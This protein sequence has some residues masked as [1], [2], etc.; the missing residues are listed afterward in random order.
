MELCYLEDPVDEYNELY[1]ELNVPIGDQRYPT[2]SVE[3][4]AQADDE[5]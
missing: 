1:R 3:A 2:T 5:A 4:D